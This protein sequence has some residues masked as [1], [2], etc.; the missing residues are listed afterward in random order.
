[1]LYRSCASLP[2]RDILVARPYIPASSRRPVNSAYVPSASPWQYSTAFIPNAGATARSSAIPRPLPRPSLLPPPS[3]PFPPSPRSIGRVPGSPASQIDS[4]DTREVETAFSLPLQS[5]VSDPGALAGGSPSVHGDG[6][7]L[8]AGTSSPAALLV[9]PPQAPWESLPQ[10]RLQSAPQPPTPSAPQSSPPP[11]PQP[12]RQAS[13]PESPPQAPPPQIPPPQSPAR[14]DDD[15]AAAPVLG[16]DEVDELVQ[17]LKCV[18]L[19]VRVENGIFL[20]KTRGLVVL[21]LEV[22]EAFVVWCAH[23]RSSSLEEDVLRYLRPR[24]FLHVKDGLLTIAV[25]LRSFLLSPLYLY[26]TLHLGGFFLV[27]AW[28]QQD[29]NKYDDIDRAMD[30]AAEVLKKAVHTVLWP[31]GL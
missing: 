2:R 31:F 10:P 14:L 4:G 13:P 18:Q 27:C 7:R 6:A 20:S 17:V 30:A 9:S 19:S 8:V 23:V 1:M 25:C 11:P 21:P 22:A 26:N 29:N 5:S 12:P 28:R 16:T 24:Y 3:P 15:V